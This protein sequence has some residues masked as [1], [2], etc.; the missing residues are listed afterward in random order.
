MRADVFLRHARTG[1]LTVTVRRVRDQVELDC[2]RLE[3]P[4]E[5][6]LHESDFGDEQTWRLQRGDAI[7]LWDRF[8]E[9][10]E[11]DCYAVRLTAHDH[12]WILTW[13]DGHPPVRDVPIGIEA[14]EP[15]EEDAVVVRDDEPDQTE[16]P[17]PR[18]PEG[19]HVLPPR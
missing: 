13:R 12:T 14:G 7:P 5:E 11:R 17:P 6:A 16:P 19:V 1:E 2:D 9:A 10:P 15:A 8:H 4:P 3:D 18:V